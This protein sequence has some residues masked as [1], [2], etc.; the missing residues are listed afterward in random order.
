MNKKQK[1]RRM[2]QE[3]VMIK[4]IEY[5]RGETN[6]DLSKKSFGSKHSMTK[7]SVLSPQKS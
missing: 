6:G 4:V 7:K 1:L 2:K 5:E 3:K